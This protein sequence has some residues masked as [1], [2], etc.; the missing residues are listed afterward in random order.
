MLK[1]LKGV[2]GP[3]LK[4][5]HCR[6]QTGQGKGGRPSREGLG[7]KTGVYSRLNRGSAPG[8]ASQ[9]GGGTKMRSWSSQE[10]A[11]C[12]AEMESKGDYKEKNTMRKGGMQA[13]KSA[14][15]ELTEKKDINRTKQICSEW[16]SSGRNP[17]GK[18]NWLR[19]RIV[20]F[21]K[22]AQKR[23][24]KGKKLKIAT[25]T[26]ILGT[27]PERKDKT[28]ERDCK[29]RHRATSSRAK[30]RGGSGIKE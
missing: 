8:E 2:H 15:C 9:G 26:P 14:Y 30:G 13:S 22:K 28:K 4:A 23:D 16:L 12:A 11:L 10:G 17:M 6:C 19:L 24:N 5:T 7:K 18:R 1:K 21:L 20:F 25:T 3:E 29:K 27:L